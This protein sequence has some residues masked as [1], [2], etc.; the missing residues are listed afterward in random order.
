MKAALTLK[1]AMS[2]TSIAS[3]LLNP[4][5][6][7]IAAEIVRAAAEAVLAVVGVAAGV[8]VVVATVVAEA[9]V[10]TEVTVGMAVEAVVVT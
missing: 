2:P 8:V 10:V 3:M 5:V 4:P 1:K 6:L 7:A 9:V